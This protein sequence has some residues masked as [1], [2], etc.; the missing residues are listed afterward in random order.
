MLYRPH[1]LT[2]NRTLPKLFVRS[3]VQAHRMRIVLGLAGVNATELH[4]SLT[5]LQAGIA[6]WAPVIS[7]GGEERKEAHACLQH[8][9]VS[10]GPP[11]HVQ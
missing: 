2:L 9:Y 6:L 5:Q 1:F 10:H 7:L 11:P 8:F 4:G 3:K